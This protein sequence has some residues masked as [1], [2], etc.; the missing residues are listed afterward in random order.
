[1]NGS[2]RRLLCGLRG[3]RLRGHE[4]IRTRV[5][6]R[7]P[8]WRLI[9]IRSV[10]THRTVDQEA[11]ASNA[12]GTEGRWRDYGDVTNDLRGVLQDRDCGRA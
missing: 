11:A 4:K 1:M 9:D 5:F 6:A 10:T 2:L 7:S 3:V 8:L 12:Y